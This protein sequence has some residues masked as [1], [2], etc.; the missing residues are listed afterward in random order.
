MAAYAYSPANPCPNCGWDHGIP[1]VCTNCHTVG[2]GQ[3]N[4]GIGTLGNTYCGIC[5]KQTETKEVD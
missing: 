5:K 4:C 2:C 3:G 1:K